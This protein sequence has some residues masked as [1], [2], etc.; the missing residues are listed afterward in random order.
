MSDK[1]N[2]KG[3]GFLHTLAVGLCMDD[4]VEAR[5]RQRDGRGAADIARR[6]GNDGGP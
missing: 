5:P 4:N 1:T 2:S 6:A 3:G